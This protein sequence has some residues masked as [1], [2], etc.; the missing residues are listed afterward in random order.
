M[1]NL[2][3]VLALAAGVG[4][5]CAGSLPA[6]AADRQ[7]IHMYWLLNP[8]A[9]QIHPKKV[10][11][12]Y[13]ATTKHQVR[14]IGINYALYRSPMDSSDPMAERGTF[15]AKLKI[16]KGDQTIK[17]GAKKGRVTWGC[18]GHCKG[19]EVGWNDPSGC[20]PDQ[21]CETGY[22]TDLLPLTLEPGDVV[23]WTVRFKGFPKLKVQNDSER[24]QVD[25][26]ELWTWECNC[27]THDLPCG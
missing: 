25:S 13:V 2:I 1:R 19:A 17:L 14:Q 7:D 22:S 10:K 3:P 16:L 21:Q 18:G 26:P 4:L 8:E 24:V 12:A 20:L 23:M 6:E 9:T 15:V 11:L 27:G 5:V